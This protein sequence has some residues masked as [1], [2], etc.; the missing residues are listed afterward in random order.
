MKA[1]ILLNGG[2]LIYCFSLAKNFGQYIL[3]KN[4]TD[5][6]DLQPVSLV[7]IPSIG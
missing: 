3:F 5:F 4:T 6:A 2:V 7:F 1:A